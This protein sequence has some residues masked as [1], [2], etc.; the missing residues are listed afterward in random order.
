M[1]K[2]RSSRCITNKISKCFWLLTPCFFRDIYTSYTYVADR[3]VVLPQKT[4]FSSWDVNWQQIH[5]SVHPSIKLSV[6]LSIYSFVPSTSAPGTILFQSAGML[7]QNIRVDKNIIS[8][9]PARGGHCALDSRR[10][11]ILAIEL[12]KVS[13]FQAKSTGHIIVSRGMLQAEG[14]ATKKALGLGQP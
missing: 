2:L 10:V 11:T 13:L 14:T 12:G 4:G 6:C 5:P 3:E 7:G 1:R 9:I 8:V